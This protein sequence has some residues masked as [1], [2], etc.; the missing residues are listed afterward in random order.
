MPLQTSGLERDVY[1]CLIPG[2]RCASGGERE[3]LT[4]NKR[5]LLVMEQTSISGVRLRYLIASQGRGS[6]L[7][8]PFIDAVIGG[9][10]NGGEGEG[11]QDGHAV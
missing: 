4:I 10:T 9:C 11:R 3:S 8:I 5:E 6:K 2:S 1:A 7:F